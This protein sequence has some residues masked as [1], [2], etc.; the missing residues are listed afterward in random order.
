MQPNQAYGGLIALAVFLGLIG[1][2]F[3]GLTMDLFLG[4]Q[5]LVDGHQHTVQICSVWTSGCHFKS[6]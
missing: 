3:L 6:G 5:F 4:Q 2:V 1:G